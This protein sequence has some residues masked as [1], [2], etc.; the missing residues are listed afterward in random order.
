[1]TNQKTVSTGGTLFQT[2]LNGVIEL[3]QRIAA[4]EEP[5][6]KRAVGLIADAV[7]SGHNIFAFGCTHSSLPIQDLVY[8]AGG[9]ILINPIYSPEIAAMDTCPA[10]LSTDI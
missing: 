10:T 8:R 6:V 5:A 1:M 3:L 9:I 2:Y 4:E 7:Q